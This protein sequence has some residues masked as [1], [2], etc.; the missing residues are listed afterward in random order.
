MELA[1]LQKSF[2]TS[3]STIPWFVTLLLIFQIKPACVSEQSHQVI[4]LT[5]AVAA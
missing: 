3:C 4:S 1:D 2:Q 5:H